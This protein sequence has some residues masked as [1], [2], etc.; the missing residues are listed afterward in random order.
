MQTASSTVPLLMAKS[1]F[2]KQNSF[3]ES[4][5]YHEILA[6]DRSPSCSACC[7]RAGSTQWP[8]LE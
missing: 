4:L 6:I 5:L 1:N 7:A 2:T 3:I 8:S